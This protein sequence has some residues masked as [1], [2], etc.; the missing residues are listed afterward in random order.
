MALPKLVTPEYSLNLPSTGDKVRYR[1]Y[2]VKEERVLLTALETSSKMGDKEQNEAIRNSTLTVIKECTFSKIKLGTLPEFDLEYL[3]LN[4]RAKSR[5]EI[6]KPIY[7]CRQKDDK[8]DLCN[9]D[10]EI[11]VDLSKVDVDFPKEDYSKVM[12]NETV[13]VQ[14]KHLDSATSTAHDQIENEVDRM[15][16]VM[17]DS[18]DYIFDADTIYKGSETTKKELLTFIESMDESSF[19]KVKKFFDNTPKLRDVLKFDCP[20]CGFKQ[21]IVIEGLEDFFDLA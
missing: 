17:V 11:E 15:F 3:F 1:P 21:D 8:G 13:G 7:T 10:V 5:G 9:T 6:V 20:K 14:F 2:L 16:R 12:M 19:E 18:I 4:I